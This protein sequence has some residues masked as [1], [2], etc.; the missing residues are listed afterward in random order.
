MNLKFTAGLH[1]PIRRY[2][3]A[4]NTKM[5]GFFN[6]FGAGV[7]AHARRLIEKQVRQI[8][9]DE[10]P[11]NFVFDD[12]GFRWKDFRA[13]TEEIRAARQG[14]LVPFGTGGVTSFGSCSFDEP[15]DDLRALGLLGQG[16]SPRRE[17]P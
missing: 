5:H 15:R 16:G 2:D 4:V 3:A 14:S 13:S 8:I 7:L 1:H 12:E 11:A 6:V 10:D 9:A 17:I